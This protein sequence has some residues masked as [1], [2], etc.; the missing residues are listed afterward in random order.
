MAL[1]VAQPLGPARRGR[2]DVGEPLGEGHP[3]TGRAR[4]Y[5]RI[6]SVGH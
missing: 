3:W 6:P 5:R 2:R 1:Q 4:A